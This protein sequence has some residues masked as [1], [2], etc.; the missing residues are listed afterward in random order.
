MRQGER[1]RRHRHVHKRSKISHVTDTPRGN[2]PVISDK[3]QHYSYSDR[4]RLVAHLILL[5]LLQHIPNP[6]CNTSPLQWYRSRSAPSP[7]PTVAQIQAQIP[8]RYNR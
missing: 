2:H 7:V 4:H 6:L 3:A 5:L 8:H 1:V